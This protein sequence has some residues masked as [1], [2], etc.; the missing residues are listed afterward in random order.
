VLDTL[1]AA[2]MA[3][4]DDWY[5]EHGYKANQPYSNEWYA[6]ITMYDNAH[7]EGVRLAAEKSD[8]EQV[9]EPGNVRG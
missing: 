4:Y 2:A 9:V 6:E 1:T 5:A 7:G 3:A 8:I